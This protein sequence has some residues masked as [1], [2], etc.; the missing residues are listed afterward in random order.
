MAYRG[1]YT[2]AW[3]LI[4]DGV[5][6]VAG[7]ARDA[8]L[9]TVTLAASYHAGK[10]LRPHGRSGKVHF[11]VDGTVYFAARPERYGSVKPIVNPLVGDAGDPFDAL[12]REAPDLARVGWTVC[13]HNTALGER[14]PDLVTRNCFGDGYVYSLSP[15]HPAARDYVVALCADLAD[16]HEL[17]A[18]ALETPGWL[19]FAHGFHHEFAMVPLDPWAETLL[20]LD[21]SDAAVA[22]ARKDGVDAPSLAARARRDLEAH[23]AAD[24]TVPAEMA[25]QW[26]LADLAGDPDWAAF[27][28]S[29][30]RVVTDLVAEVRAALP[31]ETDLRVIPTVQRPT[32]ACW[33]EGSDLA[34]LA[35]VSDGLEIPAYMPDA[36]GVLADIADVR[37]RS[38]PDARLTAILR[39]GF[40]DLAHGA[41]T[42]VAAAGLPAHGVE[43]IAFYNYGHL[44]LAALDRMAEAVA[45]FDAAHR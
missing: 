36:A 20:A 43:G 15:A 26:L 41:E 9:D 18:L 42:A 23:L 3:D 1:L 29:R 45:A 7:R 17:K 14:H 25:G 31:R 6:T 12:A 35:R 16:R 32:A 39:P 24:R 38:G 10:F 2:Y 5:A 44:R 34:G 30:C 40:P 19:P 37:R 28:R 21:F 22:E 27:F 8:G 4:D 33:L 13:L 11:P